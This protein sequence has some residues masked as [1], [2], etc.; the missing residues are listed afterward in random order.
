MN[1]LEIILL[2][3]VVRLIIPFGLLLL[4]GEWVHRHYANYWLKS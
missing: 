3:V 1:G 4:A 2:L